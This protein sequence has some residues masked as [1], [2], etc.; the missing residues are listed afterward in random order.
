MKKTTRAATLRDGQIAISTAEYDRLRA[1]ADAG[2]AASAQLKLVKMTSAAREA[3][4][5]VA[6]PFNVLSY[7]AFAMRN[8][9]DLAARLGTLHGA[10]DT[11]L[12][13]E[14]DRTDNAAASDFFSRHFM[15]RNNIE[16]AAD[17]LCAASKLRKVAADLDDRV[18][19]AK[20]GPE[21]AKAAPAASKET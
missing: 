20:A 5:A 15:G 18:R 12:D 2:R 21:Q 6:V 10:A 17:A 9:S 13:T 16:L 11:A 14:T 3:I 19:A 7:V 1:E 8:S 4:E